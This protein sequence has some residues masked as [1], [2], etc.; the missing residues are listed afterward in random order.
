M[1]EEDYKLLADIA[2]KCKNEPEFLTHI[3]N[4]GI[5]GIIN[6]EKEMRQMASDMETMASAMAFLAGKKRVSPQ[7]KEQMSNLALSKLQKYHNKSFL[8]WRSVVD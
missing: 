3:I 1:K 8:N 5:G 6:A 7:L 2:Y 4:A